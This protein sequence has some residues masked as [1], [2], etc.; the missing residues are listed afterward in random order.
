MYVHA[1]SCQA[2]AWRYLV[3]WVQQVE[4]RAAEDGEQDSSMHDAKEA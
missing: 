2:G 1:K 3:S 4:R